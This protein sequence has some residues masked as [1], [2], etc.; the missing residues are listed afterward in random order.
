MTDKPNRHMS[1][2]DLLNCL[3]DDALFDNLLIDSLQPV[4]PPEDFS[5]RVMFAIAEESAARP[6][7]VIQFPWRRFVAGLSTCAAA[8]ALFI[9]VSAVNPV[10]NPAVLLAEKPA[11]F[12]EEFTPAIAA[13]TE[14]TVQPTVQ[15]EAPEKSQAPADSKPV[16]ATKPADKAAE[17][18]PNHTTE[19]TSEVAPLPVKSDEFV[20]PRA[21]YGTETEGTLSTRLLATIEGNHLYQPSMAGKNAVFNTADD[22]FVYSWRVNVA[23]PSEPE[24]SAMAAWSDLPAPKEVLQNTTPTVETTTLVPSPDK[25]MLAQN[26]AD[27]VWVSLLDGDVFKLTGEGKGSLLAWSPDSSK[28]VFTNADGA[29]F[30]GYPFEKRIYQL[31]DSNVKDVCW[32]SDN[33]TLLYVTAGAS[34]DAL[35]IVETY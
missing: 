30:V 5:A 21:A 18:S 20:L 14:K 4:S 17:A 34:E 35:Y 29:L 1:K 10:E 16:E 3:N 25:T 19:G 15:A 12:S 13:P 8:F 6:A 7:K 31:A 23:N 33:K 11:Q 22:E 27:G 9:G 32:H 26:S 2:Q 24:C 28:L